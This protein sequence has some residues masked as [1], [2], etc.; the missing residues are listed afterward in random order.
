M[1]EEGGGCLSGLIR[2]LFYILL[3]LGVLMEC[4]R[5][6]DTLHKDPTPTPV[7]GSSSGEMWTPT[8]VER[9]PTLV[10]ATIPAGD[11]PTTTPTPQP[12][13]GYVNVGLMNMRSGPGTEYEVIA[14]I[15]KGTLVGIL[16][17]NGDRTW[18][19]A[20][21]PDGTVGWVSEEYI[22]ESGCVAC[23]PVSHISP[24]PTERL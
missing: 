6:P 4:L 9:T 24:T 23:V 21:L 11:L 17:T 1:N 3:F 13:V 7:S 10:A 16:G 15:A 22:D 12:P 14:R 5:D 19:E 20:R 2:T 8:L 18:W